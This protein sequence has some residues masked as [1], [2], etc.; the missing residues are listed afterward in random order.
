MPDDGGDVSVVAAICCAGA[1]SGLACF[2]RMLYLWCR[3]QFP[4]VM[5]PV[6]VVKKK[7]STTGEASTKPPSKIFEHV[8]PWAMPSTGWS[9]KSAFPVARNAYA[10]ESGLYE[11]PNLICFGR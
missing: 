7:R 10:V 11:A 4:A 3:L 8:S 1:P 6:F 9:S 2:T 5:T